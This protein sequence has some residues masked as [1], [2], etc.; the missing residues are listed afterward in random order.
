MYLYM[1]KNHDHYTLPQKKKTKLIWPA[2]EPVQGWGLVL[3]RQENHLDIIHEGSAVWWFLVIRGYCMYVFMIYNVVKYLYIYSVRAY[4]IIII[5]I[6][7]N[8]LL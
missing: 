3:V 4:I 7:I 6:I 2:A 1:H 8:G 5:T